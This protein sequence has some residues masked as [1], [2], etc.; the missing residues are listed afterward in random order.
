[1]VHSFVV[2]D[3]AVAAAYAMLGMPDP[4]AAAA[5]LVRGYHSVR[6]LDDAEI[7]AVYPLIVA[8][9]C[10][11]ATMAVCQLA[12]APDNEYLR[13]SQRQVRD[14]LERLDDV[15][16]DWALCAF[17]HACGLPPVPG[18]RAV[19]DWL[20]AH[21]GSFAPVTRHDL[22]ATPLSVL[23]LT[24]GSLDIAR[25]SEVQEPAA[26]ARFVEER[27]RRDGTRVAIGRYDEPRLVY[28]TPLFRH[29]SNW[30]DEN[31]TVHLGMDIFLEAG[32]PIF[33]PLEGTVHSF[34]DNA[35]AG[36]YGPTIILEH[37]PADGVPLLHP[38][39]PPERATR[40]RG[41]R[42]AARGAGAAI[43]RLGTIDVNG[44][45]PPHL[46]FQIVLD[47]LGARATSPAWPRP[48][49][50]TS[51]PRSPRT[52]TC[53]SGFPPTLPRPSPRTPG[54]LR[55]TRR[56][57]LGPASASPTAAR[58][59]M[60]RGEGQYL[61]DAEGRRYLDAREQRAARRPRPPARGR[62]GAPPDG[63]C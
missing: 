16:P 29:A 19:L 42:R 4:V 45:W 38:L 43:A 55:R 59:H 24:P 50:A 53:C 15:S 25:T 54:R 47:L 31:R 49:S 48:G 10:L 40:S 8:R 46:H 7:E 11:S 41:S 30:A 27:L 60:A 58:S 18:A 22:A 34:R 23:D 33:S 36:D 37:A 21:A 44:G 56:A 9:L 2:G 12:E 62:G 20:S 26:F 32:E 28:A 13:I 61:Y 5:A 14:L 57:R 3:L 1:M 17:R 6:P 63:A 39:R 51:G 52:R 35:G